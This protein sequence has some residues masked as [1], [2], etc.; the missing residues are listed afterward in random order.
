VGSKAI[1]SLCF[2]ACVAFVQDYADFFFRSAQRCFM[3][4]EILRRAAAL[5]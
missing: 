4:C 1:L 5:M 2:P 3:A